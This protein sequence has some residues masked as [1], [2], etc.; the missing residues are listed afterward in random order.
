[1]YVFRLADKHSSGDFRGRDFKARTDSSHDEVI[2]GVVIRWIADCPNADILFRTSQ[3]P[4]FQRRAIVNIEIVVA[5]LGH[6]AP[7]RDQQ[8]DVAQTWEASRLEAD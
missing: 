4:V 7:D 5:D 2:A 3:S 6:L 8:A 1:M